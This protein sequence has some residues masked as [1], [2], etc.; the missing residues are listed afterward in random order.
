M[1]GAPSMSLYSWKQLAL[2]S[3]EYSCLS[4]KEQGDGE[5]ILR[6]SWRE[7]CQTVVHDYGPLMMDE[8]SGK[9][10]VYKSEASYPERR[11]IHADIEKAGA[12]EKRG[13][14]WVKA[15]RE[16]AEAW[17]ASLPKG[18]VLL[19]HRDDKDHI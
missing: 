2:W 19:T 9:I 11:R 18:S 10:D 12:D 7:F 15:E 8:A 1:V 4:T 3:L 5:E 17:R 6:K 14:E 16:R 13:P